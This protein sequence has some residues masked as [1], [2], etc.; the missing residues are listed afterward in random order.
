MILS[1]MRYNS[2]VDRSAEQG[3]SKGR[4]AGGAGWGGELGGRGRLSV[5]NQSLREKKRK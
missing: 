3:D 4:E 2:P 1:H 5:C